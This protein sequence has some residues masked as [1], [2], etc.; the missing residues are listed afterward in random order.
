[1]IVIRRRAILEKL[2]RVAGDVV[3][4]PAVLTAIDWPLRWRRALVR[5]E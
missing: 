1:M 2:T 4:R 3:S 5:R